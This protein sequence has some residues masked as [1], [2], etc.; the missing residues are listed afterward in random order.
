MT[1]KSPTIVI[2]KHRLINI[3]RIWCKNDGLVGNKTKFLLTESLFIT[4]STDPG[5]RERVWNLSA[6]AIAL[7]TINPR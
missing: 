4:W 5:E 1:L 2:Y 6:A 3:V 7:A